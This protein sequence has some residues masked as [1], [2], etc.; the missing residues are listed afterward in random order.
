MEPC[1]L[2]A[3][4]AA[5]LRLGYA[6]LR[7]VAKQCGIRGVRRKRDLQEALCARMASPGAQ[8]GDGSTPSP[9]RSDGTVCEGG[10][11][12]VCALQPPPQPPPDPPG[13]GILFLTEADGEDAP[14]GPRRGAGYWLPD[15]EAPPLPLPLRP[16]LEGAGG[17]S[18]P[19]GEETRAPEGERSPPAL[20]RAVLSRDPHALADLLKF[21]RDLEHVCHENK[22]GWVAHPDTARVAR[23]GARW[24]VA[25]F[26][27]FHL[28]VDQN[29][30]WVGSLRDVCAHLDSFCSMEVWCL[31]T[32]T[33]TC[34]V[35]EWAHEV[36]HLVYAVMGISDVEGGGEGPGVGVWLPPSAGGPVSIATDRWTVFDPSVPYAMF[37]LTDTAQLVLVLGLA[38]PRGVP[39]GVSTNPTPP[40]IRGVYEHQAHVQS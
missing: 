31:G 15:A 37:N 33:T 34:L 23:Q 17:V 4:R 2:P 27:R 16:R 8:P 35:R 28:C 26:V 20:L 21:R 24:D 36:N 29:L 9:L 5:V 10:P 13:A 32:F 39:P 18:P 22:L 40:A 11:E 14:P 38:R 6:E 12:G 7:A 25:P 3:D 30:Q 1:P 19:A